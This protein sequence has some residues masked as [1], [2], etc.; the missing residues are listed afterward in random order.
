MPSIPYYAGVGITAP[1]NTGTLTPTSRPSMTD[2]EQ[3]VKGTQ[4]VLT[5]VAA[6]ATVAAVP[7]VHVCLLL[8]TCQSAATLPSSALAGV[9]QAMQPANAAP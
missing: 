1:T 7:T 3:P 8:Q 2:A 6:A 5:A 9:K 4:W